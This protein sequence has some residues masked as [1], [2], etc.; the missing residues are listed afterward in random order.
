MYD[1]S[2]Y[3]LAVV[4]LSDEDEIDTEENRAAMAQAIQDTV[5]DKIA[6]FRADLARRET[7]A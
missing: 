7:M 1:R 6:E 3:D 2:C 5:E 4:F